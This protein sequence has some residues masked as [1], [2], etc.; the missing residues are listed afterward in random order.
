VKG[1]NVPRKINKDKPQVVGFLGVGLD[2]EEGQQRLTRSDHFVLVGGSEET[3][4]RMQD[5]AI[6][7]DE[8]L[9]TR[10]KRLDEATLEEVIDLLSRASDQ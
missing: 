5:T 3:H 1:A 10:G 7:F 9:K 2:A 4:E 8:E 6:R